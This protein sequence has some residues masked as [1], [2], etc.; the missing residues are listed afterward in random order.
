[1]A[2]TRR[3]L[4]RLKWQV[5]NCVF[6][7]PLH[8]HAQKSSLRC[9]HTERIGNKDTPFSN[10]E[11]LGFR[12]PW[13]I[14]ARCQEMNA[15]GS[16]CHSPLWIEDFGSTLGKSDSHLSEDSS[17]QGGKEKG[18]RCPHQVHPAQKRR[19]VEP[20]ISGTFSNPPFWCCCSVVLLRSPRLTNQKHVAVA[21]ELLKG[22]LPGMS[23]V[24][25]TIC[26]RSL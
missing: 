14:G 1:M 3:Y 24:P 10:A 20:P 5:H 11:M 26:A 25:H 13:S 23:S 4:A 8:C 12:E 22:A 17:G 2:C 9:K 16:H 18:E 19:C 7:K 6:I 15:L 21:Q